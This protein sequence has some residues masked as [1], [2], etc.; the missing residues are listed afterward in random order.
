[1]LEMVYVC[2]TYIL[3]QTYRGVNEA[4]TNRTAI[5]LSVN[6]YHTCLKP[7]HTGRLRHHHCN[8][9]GHC[10]GHNGLHTHFAHQCNICYGDGDGVAWCERALTPM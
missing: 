6:N 3:M 2:V 10:D 1:M 8:I 4:E 5:A 7:V 9:D